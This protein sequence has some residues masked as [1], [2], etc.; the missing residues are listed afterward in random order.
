MKIL[1][2]S[3]D[4]RNDRIDISGQVAEQAIEN[5]ALRGC[6]QQLEE[7][8]KK[9]RKE[10]EES[11]ERMYKQEN[12][13]RELEY[14]TRKLDSDYRKASAVVGVLRRLKLETERNLKSGLSKDHF[15]DIISRVLSHA[16]S[17]HLSHNTDVLNADPY[18][19]CDTCRKFFSKSA[20][21]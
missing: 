7:A 11:R 4:Y 13:V 18:C 15:L 19:D 9:C 8:L 20:P 5:L 3:D 1:V 21:R 16:D 14:K 6:A 10:A 12:T 2:Q 17:P